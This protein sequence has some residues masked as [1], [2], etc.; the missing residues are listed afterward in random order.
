MVSIDW[1]HKNFL[2]FSLQLQYR[3]HSVDLKW[4]FDCYCWWRSHRLLQ[5]T[6]TQLLN[7][8]ILYMMYVTHS[9][10]DHSNGEEERREI[11]SRS[12]LNPWNQSF[13]FRC[14]DCG[15][16]WG[17]HGVCWVF[18]RWWQNCEDNFNC[19]WTNWPA[20]VYIWSQL[21]QYQRPKGL[22]TGTMKK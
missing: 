14:F 17:Q 8:N 20:P 13:Q 9:S 11:N 21:M 16:S 5:A 15:P 3:L 18:G 2:L 22:Y 12:R 1:D 4:I 7:C 10:F 6:V 19:M